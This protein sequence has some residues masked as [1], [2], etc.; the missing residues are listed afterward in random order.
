VY[1]RENNGFIVR[2]LDP[3]RKHVFRRLPHGFLKW[4]VAFPLALLVWPVVKASARNV[5]VPYGPY[6]RSLA[7]RDFAFTHGV[8]FDHLVAPTTHYVPREEFVEWFE[9]AGL[10]DVAITWR[11]ENSWRGLG[12]VPEAPQHAE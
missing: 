12:R 7:T 5:R 2:F 1:G 3:L 4:G 11:N 8:V 9:R 10:T 6:F